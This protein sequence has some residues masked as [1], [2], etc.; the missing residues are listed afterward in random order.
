MIRSLGVVALVALLSALA[1]CNNQTPPPVT[2][3]SMAPASAA[4]PSASP[5]LQGVDFVDDFSGA[6]VDATKWQVYQQTGL[7]LIREGRLEILNAGNQPNFPYIVSKNAIIPSDG[8]V[9]FEMN[10]QYFA[11]GAP[12]SFNLDYYPPEAPGK[13]GLTVPFM[14]TAPVATALRMTFRTEDGEK[15]ASTPLGVLSTASGPHTFRVE[16]SGTTYR[17]IID[18]TELTTFESKRRPVKFWIGN[19]PNKDVPATAWPRIAIDYVKAGVLTA[20]A[21]AMPLPTPTPSTSASPSSAP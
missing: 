12:V 19:Y 16:Y 7:V 10:F 5:L 8:P 20:P 17:V 9:F 18:N 3:A 14:T 11:S 15:V 6:S 2:P 13:E 4:P 1:A 21:S